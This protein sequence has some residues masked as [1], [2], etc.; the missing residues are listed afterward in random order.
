MQ[1]VSHLL[2]TEP[3]RPQLQTWTSFPLPLLERDAD[4][5]IYL[6]PHYS[7]SRQ[8]FPVL[9]FQ[10]GQNVF[11][12]TKPY[13]HSWKADEMAETCPSEQ[14]PIMVAISN[15]G[16]HCSRSLEYCPFDDAI[17]GNSRSHLYLQSILGDIKPQIDSHFRTHSDAA[18]TG[19][20]GA[21]LGG[22]F[23]LFVGLN[24]PEHFGFT[25]AISPDLWGW[26]LRMRA[27]LLE[28]PPH[29]NQHF[30]LDIGTLEHDS[31]VSNV[32]RLRI[33]R[34]FHRFLMRRGYTINYH[35]ID[36][37]LHNEHF[38]RL[39]LPHIFE[40][41]HQFVNRSELKDANVG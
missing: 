3:A 5:V 37:A 11:S 21:G 32:E 4:V 7:H 26:A 38:W 6:P 8:R 41:F 40:L 23:S 9:Y 30:Y 33:S 15:T 35:E 25:A 27:T 20:V 17:L 24:Y 12:N 2:N 28:R 31:M 13:A 14:L 16:D 18:H 34:T 39:R 36:H 19:I 1:L 22:L 10:D 29:P